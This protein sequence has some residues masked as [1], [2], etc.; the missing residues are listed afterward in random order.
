MGEVYRARDTRLDRTVAIKI[1]SAQFSSDAVQRQRFERE[2]KTISQL[3]HPHICVL[4][5]VG[6]Q[7]GIDFLVMECVDGETLAERLASGP[8][9][10]PQILKYGAQIADALAT[11]HAQGIV[12][13][14]IKPANIFVTLRG[15]VKVLDFGLAKRH[16]SLI[17][18][19]QTVSLALSDAGT[20]IGTA[21]YMSP[22]QARGESLDP[23]SDLFSFGA[24]LYELTTGKR[25][26]EGPTHAVI[27]NSILTATPTPPSRLRED[28]PQELERILDKALA[29]DREV[30]YQG[31]AEMKV[32][33]LRLQRDIDS[34]IAKAA[35]RD[36]EKRQRRSSAVPAEMQIY[37]L[38]RMMVESDWRA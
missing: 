24:V 16:D 31:A 21:A 12:H 28:L 6:H 13:R 25:A 7:D 18:P 4:H 22:E 3:N 14:D 36:S 35:V 34:G 1:L 8:L 10:L 17:E 38:E 33:L 9:P 19:G 5:D 2:A 27:F 26:F 32:D 30:R 15:D 23:R 37:P 20:V 11:A 29:K